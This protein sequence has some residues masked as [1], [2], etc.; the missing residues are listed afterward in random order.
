MMKKRFLMMR[1]K[2]DV[3]HLE[4]SRRMMKIVKEPL[5]KERRIGG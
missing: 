4:R 5:K 2:L 3:E 1:M